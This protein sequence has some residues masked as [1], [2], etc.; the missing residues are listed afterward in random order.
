MQTE[1]EKREVVRLLRGRV[2]RALHR[3]MA[4]GTRATEGYLS[5][6]CRPESILQLMDAVVYL[7]AA[8]Y[9]ELNESRIDAGD[10]N[11]L[12]TYWLTAKGISL[13]ERTVEDANVSMD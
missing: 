12:K 9:V 13:A 5:R 6:V 8:G 11:P 4:T 2:V 3:V 10:T 7:H 1:S